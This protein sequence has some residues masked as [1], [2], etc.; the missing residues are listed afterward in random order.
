L[1]EAAQRLAA[2]RE[3]ITDIAFE[4]G[5]EDLSNFVRSF[6]AEFGMSPRAYRAAA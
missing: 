6:R 2:S 5:F 3:R 1:R 4:S